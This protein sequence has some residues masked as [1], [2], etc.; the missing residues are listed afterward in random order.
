MSLNEQA[1][2]VRGNGASPT[3]FFACCIA[4]ARIIRVKFG[5]DIQF[6]IGGLPAVLF[7]RYAKWLDGADTN[8][9]RT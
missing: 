3:D 9:E 4:P 2:C 8:R 1:Q 5:G 7:K 6:D